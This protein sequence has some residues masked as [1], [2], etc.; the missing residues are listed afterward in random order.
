MVALKIIPCMPSIL[1]SLIITQGSNERQTTPC[2]DYWIS[3]LH[4]LHVTIYV[5]TYVTETAL[6]FTI[7]QC[8]TH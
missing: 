2:L 5:H 1:Q 6:I 3:I 4:I 8:A 7:G